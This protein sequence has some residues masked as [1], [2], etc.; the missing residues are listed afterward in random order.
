M[1]HFI[2]TLKGIDGILGL[3]LMSSPQMLT[4]YLCKHM[5]EL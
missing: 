2:L 5:A 3:E 1:K 4:Y